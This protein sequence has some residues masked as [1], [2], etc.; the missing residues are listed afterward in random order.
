LNTNVAGEYPITLQVEDNWGN[1]GQLE[2]SIFVEAPE[3]GCNKG[4]ST[5]TFVG[6]SLLGLAFF[7]IRRRRFV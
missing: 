4:S 5:S 1:I 7:F 3:T 6:I 2:F